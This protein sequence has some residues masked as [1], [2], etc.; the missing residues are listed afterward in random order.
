MIDSVIV[1]L[2]ELIQENRD[3]ALSSLVEE[4]RV[5]RFVQGILVLVRILEMHI[6]SL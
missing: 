3:D 6:E 2:A 4:S 1:N 5:K